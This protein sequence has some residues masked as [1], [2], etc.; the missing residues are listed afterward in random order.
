[1]QV[2]LLCGGL[3]TRLNEETVSKPKPMVEIGEKP[4]LWHLMRYYRHFGHSDFVLCTGY[5]G[6]LIKDYFINYKY[7]ASDILVDMAKGN[8]T[9][10]DEPQADMDWTVTI[11]DTGIPTQTGSRLKQALKHLKDDVFMATYGDGLCDVDLD[12]LL[13]HH[14]ASGK[15]ATV[16]A[17][18]PSSRFGE[19]GLHGDSVTSF[20]EKPQTGKGWIN[21]GFF[22]FSRSIFEDLPDDD[23]ITLEAGVLQPL[24]R[25]GHLSVYR[26]DGFWQCMDTL[27]E[28]QLLD[29]Y[30]RDDRAPWKIWR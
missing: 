20:E 23:T 6:H 25:E 24:A 26:H 5:K 9:L 28:K 8:V 27:R 29:Q 3:G 14:N 7:N 13:A 30:W 17:V 16:T 1:M 2:A 21:G 22:V 19:L 18:R 11:Q 10:L 12:R 15:L 4:M